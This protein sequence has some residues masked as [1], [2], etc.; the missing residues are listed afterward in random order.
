MS[1]F[2][3][4][5]LVMFSYKP[6]FSTLLA[7]AEN[8]SEC[9]VK[10]ASIV[11]EGNSTFAYF[12]DDKI[13]FYTSLPSNYCYMF[14]DIKK[15]LVYT[16]GYV[17]NFIININSVNNLR[18]TL[19][20]LGKIQ[21]WKRSLL[22]APFLIVTLY[23]NVSELFELMW[24]QSV[25]NV[26]VM[27]ASNFVVYQSNPHSTQND[28]G[29]QA[30]ALKSCP[31]NS[32]ENIT[33]KRTQFNGCPISLIDTDKRYNTYAIPTSKLALHF[34]HL[35]SSHFNLTVNHQI[36]KQNQT[37]PY[38]LFR[39]TA[40]T[41][42]IG[43]DIPINGYISTELFYTLENIW[44]VPLPKEMSSIE[45][46]LHIFKTELWILV[47]VTVIF[48]IFICWTMTRLVQKQ[49]G[50]EDLCNIA[51][52]LVCVT[53]WG[54]ISKMP[55]NNK[56]RFVIVTYII[57]AVHIQTAYT[58]GLIKVLT[59]PHNCGKS[60][61]FSKRETMDDKSDERTK[62]LDTGFN[63]KPPTKRKKLESG[64][65]PISFFK[66]YKYSSLTDKFLL[67]TGALLAMVSGI[68]FS[69]FAINI[70]NATSVLI[71]FVQSVN[72]N[73]TDEE[74]DEAGESL[75]EGL[76]NFVIVNCTLAGIILVCTYFATLIFNYTALNQTFKIRDLFLR[77]ILNQDVGWHDVNQT[78]DFSSRIAD[79]L[80]KIEEGIGEKVSM[81]L[82][83]A[84]VFLT[85]LI[86]ALLMGWELALVCMLS[87][88]VTAT[89][90]AFV[91][92]VTSKFTLQEMTAYGAAGAVAEEVFSAIRT[93]TAFGG[94]KKE[95]KRYNKS[96]TFACIN[97]IKR[98]LYN[99]ICIG[100][101]FFS[102]YAC[103]AL[104]FWYGVQKILA[105]KQNYSVTAMVTV[106][107]SMSMGT[108]CLSTALPY[109][110]IFAMAKGAAVRIF[111]IMATEPVINASKNNGM[112]YEKV[113]GKITFENVHFSYPAR[114]GVKVLEN[115][116][117]TINPGETVALVGSSG[118]GKSTCLQLIQRY[119]DPEFGNVL[120]DNFNLAELD[121]SWIRSHI[122]VVGQEPILFDT[123]I[124]ENIRLGCENAT[125]KDIEAAAQK[126]NA[127]NFIE[128]FPQKYETLVGQRGTQLSGGQKQRIAIARALVRK[129]SI[130]LLDEATSALDTTSEAIVQAA[131]DAVSTECTTIIIAHRLSTIKQADRIVVM[132]EGR[133]QEEGTHQDLLQKKGVY[134]AMVMAQIPHE[135]FKQKVPVQASLTTP[136]LD[137]ET[138]VENEEQIQ[139]FNLPEVVQQTENL[140][141]YSIWPIIKYN[142]PEWWA[143]LLGCISSL[144]NGAGIPIYAI[145]FGRIM[146]VLAWD[147]DASIRHE[148][149][150]F[151]YMFLTIAVALGIASFLQTYMFGIAGEKLTMRLRSKMFQCYLS[152]DMSYFDRAENSV[153]TLCTNLSKETANLQGATGQ[154]ISTILTSLSTVI[155]TLWTSFYF[156]WRVT[157]ASLCIAPFIAAAYFWETKLITQDDEAN[158]KTLQYSTKI[159]VEAINQIRTVASLG[160]E[161]R[162][163]KLY[164]REIS[165]YQEKFNRN[166]HYHGIVYGLSRGLIFFAYAVVLCY[167]SILMMNNN[168]DYYRVLIVSEGITLSAWALGQALA[169][170]PNFQKG[171][172]AANRISQ[173]LNQVP[174][175][176]HGS[177]NL[178]E[179]WKYPNVEYNNVHFSYPSRPKAL[180]LKDF[181]MKIFEGKVI[182]LV[183]P[184][185][186]GKST[187]VQLL[188]RFY[189]PTVGTITVDHTPIQE[190]HLS[191]L[192]SQVGV[193]SQEPV[194]FS[195]SIADNISY[196]DNTRVVPENEII[197]AARKA[198]IHDFIVTLPLG[199]DTKL[200]E[201][202]TQLS[203][204]QKQRIAIARALIRN[205]K[206]L[207]LDEATSALDSESEMIVQEALD[208]AKKGRTCIIIA[209]RL[210]TIQ[211]A[212]LIC[213]ISHGQIVEMGSHSELLNLRGLYHD[214]CNCQL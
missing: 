38:G 117:L 202:G 51:I 122:G 94:E 52:G 34:I 181:D 26:I 128:A 91:S 29:K 195:L 120:I 173:I 97:N 190:M 149:A 50:F 1:R 204:G 131:L 59:L 35:V 2:V 31:C 76:F 134:F 11:F 37:L 118:C 106:F 135:T 164:M 48:T 156:E 46:L 151:S 170:T 109:L 60:D 70:G 180:V 192:R 125:K 65:P 171:V 73:S 43:L 208:N 74:V 49:C 129:P 172:T 62:L 193:V 89:S 207:L 80:K 53:I 169:F 133:V 57:Y 93:V 32:L 17:D 162:F 123:T 148:T 205:P 201:K 99:G 102:M 143:I 71:E 63:R 158:Y 212:D 184:S 139:K 21:I 185:G 30:T 176:R 6:V 178:D 140:H 75:H 9:M 58:S 86:Q 167:G 16:G 33:F 110:E 127:H 124:A 3:I 168:L 115:Y 200:G 111:D 72:E 179:T 14:V 138:I 82:Y 5:A 177:N 7:P 160:C 144:V 67:I 187:I 166:S 145:I 136:E 157:L 13:D 22:T 197:E 182:A 112:V 174:L 146:R 41:V 36:I 137:E 40:I 24:D 68:S 8:F 19:A 42:F 206:I 90:M 209:H 79:D 154:R 194:L 152:Q 87:L 130:L 203:G 142:L 92:Y 105:D 18:K 81:F 78:G 107:F 103:F 159:A 77:S 12:F 47:I 155:F 55:K 20:Y 88:P 199:Y 84:S 189:D 83:F 150:F 175:V 116:N 114:L 54:N 210:N 188:V 214:F 10:L 163:Y 64:Y 113:Q 44:L 101:M 85:C 153:G 69:L 196:G 213:V 96:L 108:W 45:A 121:L 104:G 161:K 25:L 39:G 183:G 15:P 126:A 191:A 211:D 95:E 23:K 165:L 132:S 119:Y 147:N 100:T 61:C 66:L 4:M 98:S 141:R 28:C 186:C 27:D 56:I 198:N